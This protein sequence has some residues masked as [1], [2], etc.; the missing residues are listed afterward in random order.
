MMYPNPRNSRNF[1]YS[2]DHLLS[3]H[4]II[5]DEEI[6]KPTMYDQN[7]NPCIMVI[8][9]GRATGLTV[10]RATDILSYTCNYFGDNDFRVSKEW[11]IRLFGFSTTGP[12]PSLPKAT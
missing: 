3:L 4:G 10:R 6:R 1:D 8:K 5:T 2:G 9:R 7:N 12:A 11:A